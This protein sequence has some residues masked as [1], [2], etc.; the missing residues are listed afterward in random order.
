MDA[1]PYSFFVALFKR[2]SAE[3]RRTYEPVLKT[4]VTLASVNQRWR[5]MMLFALSRV[6]VEDDDYRRDLALGRNPLAWAR[7]RYF[8]CDDA[9][10]T[11]YRYETLL[12]TIYRNCD[13][14]WLV[15]APGSKRRARYEERLRKKRALCHDNARRAEQFHSELHDPIIKEEMRL[16]VLLDECRDRLYERPVELLH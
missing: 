3:E 13:S 6:P 7:K 8:N 16:L 11:V 14:Y 15:T 9:H 2:L 10:N 4:V 1:P 12:W 5:Q